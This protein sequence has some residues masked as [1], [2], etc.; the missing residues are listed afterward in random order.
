MNARSI[1]PRAVLL[2]SIS[3]LMP[4]SLAFAIPDVVVSSTGAGIQLYGSLGGITA[5]AIETTSCNI[6]N[7]QLPWFSGSSQH[8]VIAQNMYRLANG[9]FEQ[10]GL[11]WLKHGWCA[12]DGGT[13]TAA[14]GPPTCNPNGSC[15]WLG[16]GCTDTYGAGLNGDQS[17]L[18]PRSEVNATTGIFPYPYVMGWGQTGNAIYKRLQVLTSD[19][20][21]ASNPGALYWIEGHY[22]HPADAATQGGNPLNNASYKRI[23]IAS[24]LTASP[25]GSTIAQQ[26]AIG[27]WKVQDPTVH[28]ASVEVP[29]D[30]RYWVGSKVSQNGDGTWHYEYA[31]FNLNS[32]RGARSIKVQ[33]GNSALTNVGFHDVFY[34]SGEPYD[35]ADWPAVVDPST[36]MI[37]WSTSTF[38][39]NTNANAIR[40]STLYN[41]RFDSTAP[42]KARPGRIELGLFRPGGANDP[43]IV[44]PTAYVPGAVPTNPDLLTP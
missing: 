33:V 3:L 2:V 10:I 18:G 34:H 35:G 14:G 37:E 22:V 20:A 5:Y 30:G 29:N 31:V 13:C 17:D 7:T 38:A 43:S 42:P 44:F 40:W 21:P 32:H 24:N 41:F 26:P 11:S 27:A 23:T 6:G 8:P 28:L 39:Q 15:D 16:V 36:Q 25:V 19:I 12:A 1:G 4:A 9:R